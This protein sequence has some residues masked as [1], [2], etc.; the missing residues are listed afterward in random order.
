MPDTSIPSTRVFYKV[1]IDPD[2]RDEFISAIPWGYQGQVIET[3]MTLFLQEIET[4]G[5]MLAVAKLID[6]RFVLEEK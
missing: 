5:S 4:H 2:L 6:N 3:L 1:R